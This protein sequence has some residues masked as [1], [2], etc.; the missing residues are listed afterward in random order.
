MFAYTAPM[1]PP[2]CVL[3]YTDTDGILHEVQVYATRPSKEAVREF[4][5]DSLAR[6]QPGSM[7]EFTVAVHQQP[8][9]HRLRLKQV[10]SWA[11]GS[12]K[13]PQDAIART[14]IRELLGSG[15]KK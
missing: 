11:N 14:R 1:H 9:T 12:G 4:H 2:R 3:S 6:S 10:E 7:T 15:A 13:S 8:V 5:A